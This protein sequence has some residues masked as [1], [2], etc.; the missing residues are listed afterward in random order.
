MRISIF[1]LLSIAS[2]SVCHGAIP[3]DTVPRQLN[4]VVVKGEK[5]Q[6]KGHDGIMS[7]DL[8]SI[9]KDKPVN[10]I[11]E[12]LGYLPGVINNNGLIGLAGTSDVSIIINGEL[13]NMPLPNLY[14]L[15]YTTPIDRLKT[16]E[17]M[18]TAP[19]KYHVNGAVINV[20]LKT[21][22]PLD[23][24]Q[25][26]IRAGYN[27]GHYGSFGGGLSA[28]YT[29]KDWTFDLNY[30]LSRSKT[31]NHEETYS[32]H[33]F[34]EQRTMI[35]DDMRRISESW[36]NTIYAAAT[37]KRLRLIYNGQITSSAKG[38][39]LSNGTLGNFTN[40]YNYDGPIN[41]HNIALRYSAP[42]GL[43]IGGDYTYY[44][45]DRSQSLFQGNDYILWELNKQDINR[46]HFYVDQQHQFGKWQ[47]NYGVEYQHANDCSSQVTNRTEDFEGFSGRTKEDVADAYIGLQ[48]SFEWGLSFNVSAKG[49][50][51]RNSFQNNWN[52]MPQLGATYYKTPKSIFQ[53][54]LSTTR[55]YPSYW[56]LHNGTS[57]INPYSIVLGNTELQPYL[58]YAGQLSYILKQKYVATLYM[59]YADKATVQLPYQSPNEMSLIYQT[60]NM[61]YKRVVGLNLNIPFH[62]GYIWNA[63]A[64]ANIFNQREK[65]DRFH[66]ISFD[67]KKWIFY[68]ALNSSFKLSQNSPVSLSVDFT[69]VSPS[70]QGL[71]DLSRMWKVD[72]GVKWQFGRKR[73]CELDLQANDIF[74]RWSPTMTINHAGQNYRMKVHD[75]TRN[76]KL[77][78][79]WKF[80]GF[81][82]KNDSSIDT[83]RFGTG[84]NL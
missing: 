81:K 51:Y 40:N 28:T 50:Y 49:E 11:L 65:A 41:Y 34:E 73:C 52:F 45:E 78:F 71:A 58:S 80:N 70:I 18:Y 42:F 53:L 12:A 21:P 69:Y 15:L 68:C 32:N 7:V 83:S 54:N 33:L 84:N 17:V 56:E 38:W 72:A 59:Q 22:T 24:L 3:V 8:P 46:G 4:E 43:T 47:L 10:N 61:N 74:N 2:V 66:D 44:G 67:N 14:Q 13:A 37:Y 39:S 9:V 82:P 6:V 29:V 75:M 19:A 16:V 25:G 27:Q 63:T 1:I 31:W 48:R 23:G 55:V 77:T 26:Q 76:L 30:G 35:K 64:I 79:I 60:I 20:V 36:S 57:H 62:I 5:P